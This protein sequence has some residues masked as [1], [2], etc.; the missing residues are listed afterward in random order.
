[1]LVYDQGH[2][3]ASCS[4]NGGRAKEVCVSGWGRGKCFLLYK[5]TI[6]AKPLMGAGTSLPN[7]LLKIPPFNTIKMAIKFHHEFG[8]EQIFKLQHHI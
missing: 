6:R 2:P 1:M 5:I 3:A 7:H 8:R 4:L